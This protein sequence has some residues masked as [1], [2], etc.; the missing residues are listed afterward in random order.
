M[1]D[2]EWPV[3]HHFTGYLR[4]HAEVGKPFW[5]LYDSD[6]AEVWRA[7][8]RAHCYYFADRHNVTV[9]TRH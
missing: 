6:G 8:C 1:A 4:Q 3:W 7:E 5:A 2:T 9:M